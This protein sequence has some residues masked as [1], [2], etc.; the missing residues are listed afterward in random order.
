MGKPNLKINPE[1]RDNVRPFVDPYL[2]DIVSYAEFCGVTT[3]INEYMI[4][5]ESDTFHVLLPDYK[6][7]ATLL[8]I[9]PGM[10]QILFKR[11]MVFIFPDSFN[12]G[13]EYLDVT[14]KPD[15]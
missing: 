11:M 6:R 10:Y 12:V 4:E 13:T 14:K 2:S 3:T 7:D 9:F 15:D 1:E 8:E 5:F